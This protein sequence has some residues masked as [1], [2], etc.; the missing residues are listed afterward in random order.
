MYISVIEFEKSTVFLDEISFKILI[1]AYKSQIY[2]RRPK[3]DR[4]HAKNRRIHRESCVASS[5]HLLTMPGDL[6]A[7]G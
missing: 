6:V 7:L 5:V 3:M 1:G 2:G 4:I